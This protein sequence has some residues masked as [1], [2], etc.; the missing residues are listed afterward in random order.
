MLVVCLYLRKF[1]RI[2]HNEL[3]KNKNI[4]LKMRVL[5]VFGQHNYGDVSRGESPEYS[6]F[7]PAFKNLGY[8][9]DFFDSWNRRIYPD[10]AHLNYELLNKVRIFRPDILFTVHMNYELWLESIQ[11]IKFRYGVT[12]LTWATDD[13]WK[14]R[15]VSRFIAG[16]YDKIVTT[17]PHVVQKYKTDGIDNVLVSQWAAISSNLRFP[18]YSDCCKYDVT[19]I[20]TSHGTRGKMIEALRLRGINVACFGYG[21]PNGPIATEEIPLIINQSRICLNFANSIGNN[22]I[23]ARVFEVPGAGGF[24]LTE[25]AR[26]LDKYYVVDE[27]IVVFSDFEDLVAKIKFYLTNSEERD[28]IAKAGFQRTVSEHT[29]EHRL[30]GML[31]FDIYASDY[32]SKYLQISNFDKVIARHKITPLLKI[33]RNLIRSLAILIFGKQKGARAARRL[34]YEISWRFFGRQTF[35]SSGFP[36]RLFPHD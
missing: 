24:L 11:Y 3:W 34:V 1:V 16:S 15:E 13:S 21:W 5:C 28:L 14:Y 18:Q 30:K 29:Y 33:T 6:A 20:G 26:D 4:Y 17:Y 8:E 2:C 32:N 12:A 35:T 27:E 31:N 25:N 7:I 22:Q 36:G 19:F 10:L 23:K 9:V